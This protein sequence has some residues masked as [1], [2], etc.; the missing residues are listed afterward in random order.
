VTFSVFGSSTSNSGDFRDRRAAAQT[1]RTSV[2][3]V[4]SSSVV[5]AC[6]N[7]PFSVIRYSVL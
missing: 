7:I 3:T 1:Y 5:Q 4:F 6:R 2:K